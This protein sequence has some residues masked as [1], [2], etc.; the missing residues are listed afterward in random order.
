MISRVFNIFS[1]IVMPRD[2]ASRRTVGE[3]QLLA[4]GLEQCREIT[5]RYGTSFYFA[6]QFF[7]REVRE[8]IYAI[9]AFAR[10]PDEIVDDPAKGSKDETLAKLNE[11]SDEWRAAMRAGESSDPVINAIVKMFV[12]FNISVDLGD[13]FLRSMF[14]DEEK[15]RYENYAELEEYM[16]GSAGVIGLMVTRVVGYSTEEAFPHALKLG[17]AFQLTNFLRD[18]R[19]DHENL[20]R[21][22]MPQDEMRRFGLS[23]RDIESQNYSEKFV[24]FMNFQIARNRQV[25]R[26]A[27]PGIRMLNWRGRLAVR[28][29]YVLYKAILN[30]I[31]RVNHNVYLGRVRTN[32]R[33]K[34]W[35]SA[36][37]LVGVYE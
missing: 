23:E 33:Q 12:K 3:D 29:S 4:T 6:T 2:P 7:P 8:G 34:L 21:I 24:E 22:Y 13:A 30:E 17:Y 36:K 9:Y 37:A 19:E 25:Y 27:L 14:M 15:F 16:Y 10:I 11:F 32:F 31:E 20:G 1:S 18:I 35:L 26:E 28:I 5:Q